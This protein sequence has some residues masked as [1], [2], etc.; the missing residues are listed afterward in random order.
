MLAK[1]SQSNGEGAAGEKAN[2]LKWLAQGKGQEGRTLGKN[3]RGGALAKRGYM[4]ASKLNSAGASQSSL[5]SPSHQHRAATSKQPVNNGLWPT[6][7]F[8]S[9]PG[10]AGKVPGQSSA[11]DHAKHTA[12]SSAVATGTAMQHCTP[13][14]RVPAEGI[15]A[16]LHL[17]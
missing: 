13:T 7:T 14:C 16:D 5:K 15:T 12:I 9:Y 2:A 1:Q 10:L 8:T 17:D 11:Q 6:E 3:A 4:T